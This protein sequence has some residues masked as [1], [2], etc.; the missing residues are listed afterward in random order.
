[1]NEEEDYEIWSEG[2]V[3]RKIESEGGVHD[4][5]ISRIDGLPYYSDMNNNFFVNGNSF[6]PFRKRLKD[7]EKDPSLLNYCYYST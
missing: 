4:V 2:Q 3:I 5:E 1:M 6:E 7:F